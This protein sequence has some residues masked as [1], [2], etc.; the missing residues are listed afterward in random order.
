MEKQRLDTS[1]III[2]YY[3]TFEGGLAHVWNISS[4]WKQLL[5]DVIPKGRSWKRFDEYTLDG[6]PKTRPESWTL[7]RYLSL[8]IEQAKRILAGEVTEDFKW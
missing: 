8:D 5:V 3:E 7:K 2:G 1:N 4:T 6:K